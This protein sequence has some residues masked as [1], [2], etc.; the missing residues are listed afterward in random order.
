MASLDH[1]HHHQPFLCIEVMHNC[2][3]S[4]ERGGERERGRI[5]Y[6]FWTEERSVEWWIGLSI[7]GINKWF[8]QG[9]KRHGREYSKVKNIDPTK[10]I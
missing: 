2:P 6:F 8:I 9:E 4:R 1:H 5:F 10:V 3:S 7:E